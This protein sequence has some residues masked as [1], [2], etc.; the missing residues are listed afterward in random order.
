MIRYAI[1]K[2]IPRIGEL[3][4]QV[5]MVHHT[6]R[7]D[8]FKIGRKYSNGELKTMLGDRQRPILVCTNER[9]EVL[10]YCFCIF[11]Q[12]IENSVLTD[13][14][15]LYIDDLCVDEKLRGKNIGREL[16]EAAVS[17]ARENGCYNLTLNVWSC[18]PS[19]IRFYEKC[20][21]VPQKIGMEFI[22]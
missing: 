4:S 9:D 20:G 12:H 21:L 1:E 15:T 11:Q 6:G 7:P 17:L 3:L 5:D 8:I 14:K 2:D 13:I 22:L 18:N 10:G 16:Y 19:A